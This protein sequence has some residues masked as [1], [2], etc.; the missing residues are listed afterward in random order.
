MALVGQSP[1][2]LLLKTRAKFRH[3]AR[4]AWYRDVVRPRIL[5]SPPVTGTLDRQCE[6]HVLTSS[7]DWLNLVWTLKSFY[8]AS[9][10]HYALC[11]H[12]DGSLDTAALNHLAHHFP[13]ARII[14]RAQAD[15]VVEDLLRDYPRSLQFRRTNILAPKVFDFMAFLKAD[16]MAAFDSDLLFFGEPTAY[17]ARIEDPAYRLNTFN[18]DTMDA[19]TV[20]RASVEPLIGHQLIARFNSGLGLA[21]RGSLRLDWIEEFLCLPGIL[22]GHFWRIEQTLYALCSSRFGVEL[23]PAEYALSMEPGI[24]HRPFR[25]YV[26]AIRHLMYGEGIAH[27]SRRGLPA[28]ALAET[29]PMR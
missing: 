6:I 12:E 23:L 24:N 2:A 1:G 25:H 26:G 14:R 28:G 17:L 10:R 27:L 11:I 16:R 18:A 8:A 15:A 22:D 21:H 20:E 3:G 5:R 7:S 29:L 4:V 13:D 19:Y 9:G